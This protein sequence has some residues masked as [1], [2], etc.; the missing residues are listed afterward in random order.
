[1]LESGIEIVAQP[2]GTKLKGKGFQTIP[3]GDRLVLMTPGG[4]GVGARL[5]EHMEATARRRRI[6]RLFVLTTRTAHWFIEHGFVEGGV[7]ALPAK[8]KAL[9]NFQRRS[10][11]LVKTI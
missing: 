5:L 3:A 8:K 2:P 6:R 1:M 7:E 11:V 4:G 10:K 9:Y